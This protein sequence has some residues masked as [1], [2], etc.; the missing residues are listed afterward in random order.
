MELEIF[1]LSLSW[2]FKNHCFVISLNQ[3]EG[4]IFL[5]HKCSLKILNLLLET[6]TAVRVRLREAARFESLNCRSFAV[7]V[8]LWKDNIIAEKLLLLAIRDW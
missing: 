1:Q 4:G 2:K 5:K 8:V 6:K 7:I 3:S